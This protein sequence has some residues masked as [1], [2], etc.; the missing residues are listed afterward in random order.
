MARSRDARPTIVP[1]TFRFPG[2][3][4]PNAQ[5]VAIVGPFNG[6]DPL[7][8]R[9]L[10]TPE[11][12]WAI[13]LYL[14]PGRFIYCFDVDGAAWLDPAD[15]GRMPNGWGSEHSIRDVREGSPVSAAVRPA[16]HLLPP[17]SL[18]EG[19]TA[20]PS[21]GGAPG[22]LLECRRE[23]TPDAVILHVRGEIDLLTCPMLFSTLR[24]SAEG[25]YDVIVDLSGLTYVD[26]SGW[27][28]FF[29]VHRFFVERAQRLALAGPSAIARKIM[30]ILEVH[31]VIPV[32]PSLDAAVESFR[33]SRV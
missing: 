27:K 2:R 23:E 14:P 24:T 4:V 17:E 18:M 16:E 33:S 26:S 15:D 28:T 12:D 13:T 31:T 25:G 10:K 19:T 7:C 30:K 5:H 11:S 29:D 6:W 22:R 8:H 3:L 20:G 21:P 1:V 32:F 9:L